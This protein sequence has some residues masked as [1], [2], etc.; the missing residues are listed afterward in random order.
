MTTDNELETIRKR[1]RKRQAR[2]PDPNC[3]CDCMEKFERA[4]AAWKKY[5]DYLQRERVK[6][7]EIAKKQINRV[8]ALEEEVEQLKQELKKYRRTIIGAKDVY[9]SRNKSG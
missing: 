7:Y 6:L 5:T 4:K 3:S 9:I 8:I 2:T 1:F